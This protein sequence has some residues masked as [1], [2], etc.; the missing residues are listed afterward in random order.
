MQ[1]I[2]VDVLRNDMK[3]NMNLKNLFGKAIMQ[4]ANTISKSTHEV[5]LSLLKKKEFT[6]NIKLLDVNIDIF[7]TKI[8]TD[9]S[10]KNN[11]IDN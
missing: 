4:I 7:N 3:D 5:M 11:D 10:I 6:T 2:V 1:E 8:K 9:G